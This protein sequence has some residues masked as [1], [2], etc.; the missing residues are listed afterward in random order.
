MS[1]FVADRVLRLA[2]RSDE[3]DVSA[4][5]RYLAD[6]VVGFLKPFDRLLKVDDID[7]VA[8]REDERLHLRVP[9]SRLVSEVDAALK[10]LLHAYYTHVYPSCFFLQP[11][12]PPKSPPARNLFCVSGCVCCTPFLSIS[13]PIGGG[14]GRGYISKAFS[15]SAGSARPKRLP[16]MKSSRRNRERR[17]DRARPRYAYLRQSE[18]EIGRRASGHREQRAGRVR[19][20]PVESEERRAEEYRLEAAEGEEVYPYEQRRRLQRRYEHYDADDARDR[21]AHALDGR[22]RQLRLVVFQDVVEIKVLDY[23]GRAHDKH[24]VDGGHYRGERPRDE[25]SGPEGRHQPHGQSRHREVADLYVGDDGAAHGADQVHREE[26][27][28]DGEG[29]DYHRAVH[30]ARVLIAEALLRR[31]RQAEHADADE[32]P[33]RKYEG[34]RYRVV[35][36]GRRQQLRVDSVKRLHDVADAAARRDD[37]EEYRERGDEHHH[38][39]D[40]VGE[41]DGAEAADRRVDYDGEAEYDEPV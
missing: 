36:S 8:L 11:P 29:A 30:R 9:A 14:Q 15:F 12:L 31:L 18:E 41:D 21:E 13:Q 10:K 26:D 16:A 7:S 33:E 5:L 3:E 35:R 4:R 28:A 22:G 19:A 37:G 17:D 20:L 1:R 27:E 6:E 34:L 40:G 24:R 2:L 38:A 23:R 39:L 25:N 32:H